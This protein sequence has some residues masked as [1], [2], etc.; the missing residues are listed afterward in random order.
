VQER[1]AKEVLTIMVRMRACHH[2]KLHPDNRAKMEV[3]V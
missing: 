1:T 3:R 2:V